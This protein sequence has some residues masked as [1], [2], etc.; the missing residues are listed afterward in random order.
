MYFFLY[1]V[2]THAILVIMAERIIFHVCV[3]GC[4]MYIN[5]ERVCTHGRLGILV[6]TICASIFGVIEGI[7]KFNTG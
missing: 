2:C 6:A 3:F 5:I 1:R 7:Y 4:G